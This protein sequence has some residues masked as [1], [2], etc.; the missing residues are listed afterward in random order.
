MPDSPPKL[1]TGP[2]CRR[3]T[4]GSLCDR[5]TLK[6]GRTYD[7]FRAGDPARHLYQ[8]PRWRKLRRIVLTE[9]QACR[10]HKARGQVVRAT[11][12]DHIIPHRG[13]ERLF[14]DRANL[15]GLCKPCHTAK[16]NQGG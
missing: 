15:Q 13:D 3:L 7:R 2:G 12:V 1:C 9:E 8:T 14:Y 11:E 4:R 16:T 10:H 6:Y 5:C